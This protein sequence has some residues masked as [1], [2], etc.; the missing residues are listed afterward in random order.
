MFNYG[1]EHFS[2]GYA[3]IKEAFRALTEDDIP[4][5]HLSAHNFRSANAKDAGEDKYYVCLNLFVFDIRYQTDFTVAQPIK[6]ENKFDVFV[7]ANIKVV[8]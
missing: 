7:P 2:Q 8:L 6:V 5:P 1:E 3:Q 4:Q